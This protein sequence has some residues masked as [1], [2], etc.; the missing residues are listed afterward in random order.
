MLCGHVWTRAGSRLERETSSSSPADTDTNTELDFPVVLAFPHLLLITQL[1]MY[2][3]IC[4][5]AC[6]ER[7]TDSVTAETRNEQPC[8]C[9]SQP[10]PSHYPLHS[11]HSSFF[12][13]IDL[14]T[15][16]P[17]FLCFSSLSHPL[18]CLSNLFRRMLSRTGHVLAS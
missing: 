15:I 7:Y 5:C 11:L 3:D 14:V 8:I 10:L 2:I 4:S 12:F 9:H 18:H 17:F 6:R 16:L 1:P 13:F